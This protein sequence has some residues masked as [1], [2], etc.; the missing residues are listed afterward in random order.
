MKYV[1]VLVSGTNDYYY[2]QALMSITTLR[3]HMPSAEVIV[4]VD[5]VTEK[6][7]QEPKR[8]ALKRLATI[9]AVPFAK[10]VPKVDR[11]RLLKTAIP[12]YVQGSFLFIDC[13][14]IICDDLSEI[15][16]FPAETAG[17]L[18][19]HVP[20]EAHVHRDMF[21][22]R[23]KKLGFHG[24]EKLDGNINGGV[25]LA[26]EGAASK[27]LFRTWNDR[28]KYSAYQ[29]HD[30]HDQPSLNEANY[31]T[32]LQMALLPGQWNCQPEH[33]G[34]AY[35]E[36][37][38]IIHYY[39]SEMKGKY[40]TPY[41]K[42]ADPVLQE[43]IKQAGEIPDDIMEMLKKPK[44]QFN[45]VHL[46]SDKRIISIMQSPLLFT[47]AEMKMKHV[48]LFHFFENQVRFARKMGKLLLGRKD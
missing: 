14:T 23:D 27:A 40:F 22:A 36:D 20:L 33:G 15:E 30:K 18:D 34:L 3:M 17:V 38:K 26:K 25:V 10:D 48:H 16:N 45:P 37:A 2:E 32:G 12:T 46:V 9:Q 41:Y 7:F 43:R 47:F 28:W 13:D 1:Y 8:Q 44:F 21:L 19:G 11:S 31:L 4:L 35:L 5:D 24:T 6:S 39:S 42:L 29:K